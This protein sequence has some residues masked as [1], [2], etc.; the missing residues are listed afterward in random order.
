MTSTEQNTEPQQEGR[1]P[2][3]AQTLG[4]LEKMNQNM[5][6]P[7]LTLLVATGV[8][9]LGL[10]ISDDPEH[11][12][13]KRLKK[14]FLAM[15]MVDGELTLA[16]AE[17]V[18]HQHEGTMPEDCLEEYNECLEQYTKLVKEHAEL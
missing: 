13:V 15:D 7:I 17:V 1:L 14:L 4:K 12:L 2:L 9:E 5:A 3:L 18:R 6:S 10:S 16:I 11:P 8:R